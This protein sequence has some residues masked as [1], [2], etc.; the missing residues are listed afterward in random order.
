MCREGGP[1]RVR[2]TD[3]G[4]ARSEYTTS[5]IPVQSAAA[6]VSQAKGLPDNVLGLIRG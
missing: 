2:H 3:F 1:R 4:T 5:Q 6:F